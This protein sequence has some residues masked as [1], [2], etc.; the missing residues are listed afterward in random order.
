MKAAKI[1]K[2]ARFKVFIVARSLVNELET[3]LNRAGSN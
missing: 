1:V 2:P 3:A